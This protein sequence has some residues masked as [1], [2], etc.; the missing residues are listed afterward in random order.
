MLARPMDISLDNAL[1]LQCGQ[2]LLE[3]K[4]L[5][6]D[7]V[8][9]NPPMI[10]YLS[11][12]PAGLSKLIASYQA[13][14]FNFCVCTLSILSAVLG[15]RILDGVEKP[16][17]KAYVPSVIVALG[18]G[19]LLM[20]PII[21]F[22]EREHIAVLLILPFFLLRWVRNTGGST[23]KFLACFVGILAGIGCCIKPYFLLLPGFA[24]IFWLCK[25][26]DFKSLLNVEIGS[27]ALAC[28]LYAAHFLL[29]PAESRHNYFQVLIPLT[30]QGY[31]AYNHDLLKIIVLD[32]VPLVRPVLVIGALLLAILLRR[33][34]SLLLPWSA[35]T[36]AGYLIFVL[37]QKGFHYHT[38]PMRYGMAML[39]VLEVMTLLLMVRDKVFANRQQKPATDVVTVVFVLLAL[40]SLGGCGAMVVRFV[41]AGKHN[42]YL[43]ENLTPPCAAQ[44]VRSSNEGDSVFFFDTG[45][46]YQ[47]PMLV[48]LNR[49][50]GSRF[51]DMSPFAMVRY[52]QTHAKSEEQ[53]KEAA[54][55][56]DQILTQ[57]GDD[58]ES[59]KTK[60]VL[61]PEHEWALPADFSVFQY[62]DEHRFF[63]REMKNYKQIASTCKYRVYQRVTD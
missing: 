33:R 42:F 32:N 12:I 54:S 57:L 22:G 27:A 35:W 43:A 26:R 28:L 2:L 47:Y 8:E 34:C 58:F 46:G 23:C 1:L 15:I 40:L 19:A 61:I 39:C 7:I 10:M 52:V 20:S 29:L 21:Y 6:V 36:V 14:C 11:M 31:Q 25:S 24:E 53:R 37:Q 60:L 48:Q 30:V 17:D 5:Y 38:I 59:R 16:D 50:P 13:P 63:Q 51:M 45:G 56:E 41:Q 4:Q 62:L 44:V 49:R 18:V 55:Y 9:I 3:K